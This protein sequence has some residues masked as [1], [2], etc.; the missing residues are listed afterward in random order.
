MKISLIF[1]NVNYR[2]LD[3][4]ILHPPLG[5][6]YLAAVLER[7]GDEVQVIDAAA[8]NLSFQALE[9]NISNF[10]P[11]IIGIT[12][13][14]ATFSIACYTSRTLKEFFPEK[15]IIF[16]GPWATSN[17]SVVL[18]K[19]FADIVVIGEGEITI[20]E[21]VE[22]MER[23]KDW[24]GIRGIAFLNAENQVVLTSSQEFLADLDDLPF[25]SWQLLPDSRK[26]AYNN[27]S[28]PY[29]PI[30]TSRGC[31]FDCIYC[32]KNIHGYKIRYRSVENVIEEIRYL[33]ENF[34]IREIIIADDNFTQDPERAEKI[35]DRIYE[36]GFDVKILFSNGIR[37]DIYSEN[38]VRKMKRAGV[39]RVCLG[40]ESGNQAVLNKIRKGLNLE[41]VKGFIKL[42]KK[43]RI[44]YWG[45]FMLGLPQDSWKTMMD[46]VNF[47]L[48]NHI[49]PHFHKT[50]AVPGTRL[51]DLVKSNL[52][53]SFS[54][55]SA[56]YSAGCATFEAYPGQSKHLQ[57]AMREGYIRYYINPRG[58]LQVFSETRS[59]QDLKW[60]F[61]S[62]LRIIQMIVHRAS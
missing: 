53:G 13:N 2:R 43:Y 14:I 4:H 31:P 9:K 49:K 48:E 29:Y 7:R 50:I 44:D 34:K 11:S 39:Y 58:I 54:A 17:Y 32:T 35:F 59:I 19:K 36:S 28:V 51:Y 5:L 57:R 15:C 56:S 20:V 41:D 40:I 37:S 23:G 8:R 26:Y 30:M 21:I 1:P 18:N 38:L 3:R 47:A 42:L 45:Y 46:T 24:R 62:S 22:C 12:T 33:K 25:P 55:K 27:R 61:N 10:Q 6:A 60:F 52:K 16:G